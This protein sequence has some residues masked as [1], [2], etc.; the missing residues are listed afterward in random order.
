[1]SHVFVICQQ[2]NKKTRFIS[3]VSQQIKVV[4]VVV[5]IV[6]FVVVAVVYVVVFIVVVNPQNLPLNL[7]GLEPFKKFV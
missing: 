7:I 6:V 2:K 5:V 3:I 4:V 1:M